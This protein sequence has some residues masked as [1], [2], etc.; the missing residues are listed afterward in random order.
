MVKSNTSIPEALANGI[1]MMLRPYCPTVSMNDIYEFLESLDAPKVSS[2]KHPYLSTEEACEYL[3][4][5]RFTLWRLAEEGKI[6]A[7]RPTARKT[8]YEKESLDQYVRG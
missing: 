1:V 2:D 7:H 5:S 3:Q 6:K 8:L 4:C